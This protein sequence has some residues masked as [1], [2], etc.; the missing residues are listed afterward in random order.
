M[1]L[2]KTI[3]SLIL[4][5]TIL[6]TGINMPA[7]NLQAA[8]IFNTDVSSPRSGKSIVNLQGEFQTENADKILKRINDIRY[9]A[10]REGIYL[11]SLGRNLKTSDYRPL[12]WSSQLESYA[13]IRAAELSLNWDHTRPNDYGFS[14]HDYGFK[15]YGLSENLAAGSGLMRSIEQYYAEKSNLVNK[16]GGITGHYTN[17]INPNMVYVGVGA[18]KASDHS[19]P[20]VYSAMELANA[21]GINENKDNFQGSAIQKVEISNNRINSIQIIASKNTLN[22]GDKLTIDVKGQTNNGLGN[23]LFSFSSGATYKT[24]DSSILAISG[25]KIEAKKA[26]S[27]TITATVNGKTASYKFTIKAADIA[28]TSLKLNKTSASINV[29]STLQLSTTIS[30]SNAT[31]KTLTYSSS[32]TAIATVDNNGKVTAKKA[33]TVTITVKSNNNKTA[34]CSITVKALD[35]AITSLKLNKTSATIS[36]GSSL[37]LST[38]ITPSNATNKT[39]TYSSS[40]TSIATVDKNGKVTAKKAGSATI[41]VKSNN[42]KTATCKI[43][44]QNVNVTSLKFNK[45]SASINVGSTLQLSTTI[46]PSNATNKTLTYSSSNTS[47]ATVDANGKV[48][49]KKAGT[50]TITVKSHN[51]KTATCKITVNNVNATSISL[52]PMI[53]SLYEGESFSITASF[54]PS[55]TT[56]KSLTY[57]SNNTN[58]ATVDA[59][60]KV[61]AKKAGSALITVKT[62]NGVSAICRI[63]VLR[64]IISA[65]SISLNIN[66]MSLYVGEEKSLIA[67]VYPTNASNKNVTYTSSNS[68]I[69]SVSSNGIVVAKKPGNATITAK[70]SNGF[71]ATCNIKVMEKAVV[72]NNV[73][74][75]SISFNYP[76]LVMSY[77]SDGLYNT[78]S[79]LKATVYPNNA[80][81]K[82]ITYTSSNNNVV[83]V[84]NNGKITTKAPGIATIKA[85]AHNGISTT[86]TVYVNSINSINYG[87]KITKGTCRLA[88]GQTFKYEAEFYPKSMSQTF[89]WKSSNPEVAKIDNNGNVIALKEGTTYISPYHAESKLSNVSYQLIVTKANSN[90]SNISASVGTVSVDNGSNIKI[91]IK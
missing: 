2:F 26:G 10:C 84:D 41:T 24:S 76:K 61:T 8:T 53:K 32:N 65:T 40:N 25:N 87:I 82:T 63:T 45:T 17:M 72:I 43:T 1:K 20:Y 21:S 5:F 69:A 50:V 57:S 90:T 52:N 31:N 68:N 39:L 91:R 7:Y 54:S 59:N 80:T 34:T 27:A 70:T 58:V 42:G 64:K 78:F 35:I 73:P 3:L 62:V 56:N 55:N 33:G 46:F 89:T 83:S 6:L 66:S 30:P 36:V 28:V 29:G 79:G 48:T 71:T 22:V 47:I 19:M 85:I 44:V 14:N 38:T 16:T 49:A 23:T 86:I 15:W 88:V 51:N 11:P 9:E 60:G 74:V 75:T 37:Q 67:T 13:R 81:D 18:F 12:K 4:V 77:N